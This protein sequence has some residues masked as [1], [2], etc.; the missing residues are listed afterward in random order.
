MEKKKM[1]K[2]N[3]KELARDI[4]KN[5]GGEENVSDLRHCITRLRFNLKD[6]SKA[7]TDYLKK[8]DGIVTIVKSAGQYQV[9]IG[10]NVGDVYEEIVE[11]SNIG[12]GGSSE[13]DNS[14]ASI[15]DRLIDTLSG[16]FQPFLGALAATGIIKGLVALLGAFGFSEADGF[17][18]LLNIVGDGFFQF[19]PM[20]L[21]VTAARRFK[22]N[23]FVGIGVAAAFLHPAIGELATGDVLYTLFAG[24]AI[25]S[26]VYSTFFGFPIILPPAGNYYSS[27]IP[28]IL[29]IWFASKVN[30][31]IKD[32]MPSALSGTLTPLLT[33]LI[34]T[35]ISLLVIGP[36]AT[37]LSALIGAMF[38]G[39]NEFSPL[40]FGGLLTGAWQLLVILGLHWG[41]VPIGILQLTEVGVSTI[42][43]QVNLS[44]F[45]IFG[46]LLAIAMRSKERK[47]KELGGSASIPALFGI[48]EPAIYGLML[49]MKKLFAIAIGI[50]VILGAYTAIFEVVMYTLG[51][52]GVFALPSFI[53]PV[54]GI[55]MNFWH[56]VITYVAAVVLG[57]IAVMIVGV[58]KIQDE[59][60]ELTP[61]PAMAGTAANTGTAT[62]EEIQESAKQEIIASPLT[63]EVVAQKEIEDEVF[64]SG[65][66]GK[67]IAINPTDGTVYA[68]ANATVTT[69]FPTGHAIGLT[70]ENGAEILIHIGLDTVELDG[71]GFEKFVQEKD[72]VTAGQKLITFDI[73]LI[74]KRGYSTQTPIVVTNTD[75]FEDILFT[76]ETSI[77][78]GDY[79]LT[80]VK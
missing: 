66:M 11:Q 67:A 10:N 63:G 47:T 38:T 79:L 9:V 26:A 50:N 64:A 8:R 37:W 18:A 20:A 4:L 14:D 17:Y 43:A 74:K 68:P 36:V 58:P 71:E 15:F 27:V 48:T 46:M 19:L 53:H 12:N 49:P 34:A 80:S 56:A 23:E 44:T 55:T 77:E 65:A 76:D 41:I 22:L 5:I 6:E 45:V 40:L 57:F 30:H 62:S 24:T 59:E 52:L 35:P 73:D 78:E 28:I 7:N 31:A 2:N 1:T 42:F 32:R 21:A 61:D 13:P 51:G 72:K 33:I 54:D 60:E 29:A 75:A 16:L 3:N 70:T 39:L 69:I 25:E